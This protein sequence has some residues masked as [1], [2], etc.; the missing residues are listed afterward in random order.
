VAAI[1]T[2]VLWES[3]VSIEAL[4]MAPEALGTE[5]WR[6]FTSA[7]PHVGLVHLV[8]NVYWLAIL[9]GA[10]E[11]RCGARATAA[12][13]LLTA[14][15]SA[16]LEHA[17]F[18]GGVGLSGIGYGL[19][20]FT[21]VAARRRVAFEDVM[22]RATAWAF[23]A[24]FVIC[25]VTTWTGVFVVGNAAHAGGCALGM[26][27]GLA[28]SH[29]ARRWLA[30]AAT[31]AATALCLVLASAPVRAIVNVRGLAQDLADE[32]YAALES[33]PWPGNIREL[34]T[35]LDVVRVLAGEAHELDVEHLPP[36][37]AIGTGETEAAGEPPDP[38]AAM[39]ASVVGR[40]L[41]E[42]GGNVSAAARQLGVA[43][44]TVYRMMER[45]GLKKP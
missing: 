37:L 6:L 26:L 9:G 15:G 35:V 2:T 8:F 30:S 32:G 12:L 41:D 40:A 17:L 33:H 36:D 7:L 13:L 24:W 22:D 23:I 28:W 31:L 5:P 29:P 1:A 39:E 18:S 44:S 38:L 42:L 34:R 14:A 11:E 3:G 19:F 27:A 43:R 20:G 21:W 25:C 16:S 45:Y 10:I 4:T